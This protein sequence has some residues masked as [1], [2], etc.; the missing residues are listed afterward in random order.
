MRPTLSLDEALYDAVQ[1]PPDRRVLVAHIHQAGICWWGG[2]VDRWCPDEM[3]FS[4]K[5]ALGSYQRL[6]DRFRKGA[7][8]NAHVLMFHNDGTFGT[9]MLGVETNDEAQTLLAGALQEIRIRTSN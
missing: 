3:L 6:V 1:I 5:K 2:D 7:T 4:S 8:T 9:V